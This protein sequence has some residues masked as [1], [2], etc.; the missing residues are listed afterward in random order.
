M[1]SMRTLAIVFYTYAFV[2]SVSDSIVSYDTSSRLDIAFNEIVID[3]PPI[4]AAPNPKK[5][6]DIIPLPSEKKLSLV[7]SASFRSISWN[8]TYIIKIG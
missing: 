3:N 8:K 6:M 5:M 2:E 4:V 1:L 7:L